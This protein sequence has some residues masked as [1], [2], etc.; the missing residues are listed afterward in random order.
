M[1]KSIHTTSAHIPYLLALLTLLYMF[2]RV[3]KGVVDEY[4]TL[5]IESSMAPCSSKLTPSNYDV[6]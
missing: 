5:L 3:G 6:D 1:I 4:W 2:G